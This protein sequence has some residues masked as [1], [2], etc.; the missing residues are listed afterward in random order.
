[1]VEIFQGEH[2]DVRQQMTAF[3]EEHECLRVEWAMQSAI[4]RELTVTL[5]Y[6]EPE[7]VET[8]EDYDR[9]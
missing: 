7:D 8:Q 6:R 2:H 5:I 3:F 4:G 1:M 9:D